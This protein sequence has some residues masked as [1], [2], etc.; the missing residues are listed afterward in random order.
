MNARTTYSPRLRDGLSPS[1]QRPTQYIDAIYESNLSLSVSVA[2]DESEGVPFGLRHGARLLISL[3][4]SRGSAYLSHLSTT[5]DASET[6]T[7][8]RILNREFLRPM[9][10]ID[11]PGTVQHCSPPG[12]TFRVPGTRRSPA[13]RGWNC[14]R[15]P[16]CWRCPH[17][18]FTAA[19]TYTTEYRKTEY[20]FC[21]WRTTA[22]WRLLLSLVE[23]HAARRRGGNRC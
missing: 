11:C 9:S 21:W 5:L 23:T 15:F 13:P 14:E 2:G 10:H 6:A 1:E 7:A 18:A 12:S 19:V 4:L 17:S 22:N 20:P 3:G 8:R 16:P